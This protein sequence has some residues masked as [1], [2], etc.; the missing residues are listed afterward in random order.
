MNIQLSYKMIQSLQ[1]STHSP[2]ILLVISDFHICLIQ[3]KS[4]I[5]TIYLGKAWQEKKK[6]QW[7]LLF[8]LLLNDSVAMESADGKD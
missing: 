7:M 5:N 2:N 1:K 4:C 6:G 8:H 3:P